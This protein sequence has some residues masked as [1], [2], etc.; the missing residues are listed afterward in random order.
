MCIRITG[1]RDDDPDS[2]TSRRIYGGAA[3]SIKLMSI[4]WDVP[5]PTSTQMLIALKLADYANDYGTSIF[6]ANETLAHK[7]RCSETTVKT[8]LKVLRDCGLL[9]LV[10]QGGS[11]PRSTN[12][13]ALNVAMLKSL[14][15]GICTIEG[16]STVLEIAG[17]CPV[18]N[19]GSNSDPLDQKRGQFDQLRGQPTGSKGSAHGPQ[20][21]NNHQIDSPARECAQA[22]DDLNLK[23]SGKAQPELR[24]TSDDGAKWEAWLAT[25]TPVDVARAELAGEIFTTARWPREGADLLRIPKPARLSEKSH[26]MAGGE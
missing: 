5:F 19:K 10:K 1:I 9:V 15:S 6:P 11:G 14:A 22:S 25:M 26:A 4:V 24:I 16:C 21:I 20:S 17:D 18:D 12:E 13:W 8:T 23:G 7:A 2:E 3:M